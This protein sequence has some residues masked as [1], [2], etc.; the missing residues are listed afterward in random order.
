ERHQPRHR[1][2]QPEP[3]ADRRLRRAARS[4]V[5]AVGRP[6]QARA[7]VGPAVAPGDV[8]AAR[9][10]ARRRG[11]LLHDR[12]GRRQARRLVAG[13]VGRAAGVARVRRRLRQPGRHEEHRHGNHDRPGDAHRARRRDADGDALVLR[14]EGADGAD[15]RDG[16]AR[17][18]AGRGR[19]DGRAA[20]G[21]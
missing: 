19:P 4:G 5:G 12:P 20:R 6:A 16:G 3:H 18:P 14:L 8:R 13:H 21:L 10:D 11:D 17:G 2:R 1:P 15:D 9:P 7:L